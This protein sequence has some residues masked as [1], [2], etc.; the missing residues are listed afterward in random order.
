[1]ASGPSDT[2]PF[3]KTGL[4]D[5][6]VAAGSEPTIASSGSEPTIASSGSEPTIA[7][8]GSEPTIASSPGTTAA[9]LG[10]DDL[11][12]I[13]RAHYLVRHELARGGMGRILVA[14]DRRLGR[15]VALK[16]LVTR[17]ADRA[18]DRR[19]ARE[20]RVTARLQHPGI[21][22]VYEAGRWPDGEPF[23][24]MKLVTGSSLEKV[25]ED[26]PELA[27][28]LHLL[29]NLIQVT[30]AMAYAHRQG[31]IHRDLKPA[32]VLV[33]DFGETVV[34]DWGLAK[35][36][37]EA[38]NDLGELAE[39]ESPFRTLPTGDGLTM[40]GSVMGTPGYMAP[41]QARGETL[42]AR[43]DVYAL[44]AM[45]WHVL[46][47]RA[48]YRGHSVEDTLKL[49]K[50][51]APPPLVEA[52]AG[53]P[54]ELMTIVRRAMSRDP[55]DR[56]ADAG[57][58]A[59][60]LNRFQAGKLVASH[61]YTVWE[62]TR[63][64]LRRHRALVTSIAALL[65][66]G[67]VVGVLSVRQIV[68][69]RD[70]AH[71]ERD[72]AH[73]AALAALEE[74][75]RL[76]LLG[77]RPR[78][79]AVPLAEAYAEGR[80]GEPLRLLLGEAMRAVDAELGA[81]DVG[82]PVERVQFLPDGRRLLYAVERGGL[83]LYDLTTRSGM[84]LEA[85]AG[86]AHD[87]FV[88]SADGTRVVGWGKGGVRLWWLDSG[89]AV[90]LARR[91]RM[92]A[93][94]PSGR[95]ALGTRSGVNLYAAS[96]EKLV[97]IADVTNAAELTFRDEDHL[98]VSQGD[99]LTV[100]DLT[101]S[102]PAPTVVPLAAADDDKATVA[103]LRC[104]A[105]PLLVTPAAGLSRKGTVLLEETGATLLDCTDDGAFLAASPAPLR[106]TAVL[107]EDRLG[108]VV[109]GEDLGPP[110][111][112][113]GALGKDAAFAALGNGRG[114]LQLWDLARG[115]LVVELDAHDR[116]ITDVA[117]APDGRTLA[118]AGEDGF[119]RWW[120][121]A[122][123]VAAPPP[124]REGMVTALAH[125]ADD[126]IVAVARGHA[127]EIE[128]RGQR[129]PLAERHEEV[130]TW[131]GFSADGGVLASLSRDG[132]AVLG[133]WRGTA[134][135]TRHDFPLAGER[136]ALSSDGKTIAS[137]G[138]DGVVRLWPAGTEL[139]AHSTGVHAVAF[140]PGDD[141][142]LLSAGDTSAW[143][144]DLA[145]R[146]PLRKL[147]A[148]GPLLDAWWDRRGALVIGA[149][150][151]GV[152]VWDA[153]RGV[154]LLHLPIV[155][156]LRAT[157]LVVAPLDGSGSRLRWPTARG[158]SVRELARETRLAAELQA[159]VVAR[160]PWVVTNG[161][162]APR[163]RPVA[164]RTDEVAQ[165]ER[166]ETTFDFDD[167]L[168]AAPTRTSAGDGLTPQSALL[169]AR[170]HLALAADEAA[171]PIAAAR[172]L[173]A[174]ALLLPAGTPAPSSLT[175]DCRDV[176]G[177]VAPGEA[178]AVAAL[179]REL[180][181][182]DAFVL[183]RALD[184][185]YGLALRRLLPL[186][187]DRLGGDAAAV[188]ACSAHVERAIERTAAPAP[189]LVVQGGLD[190]KIIRR[191]V[192]SRATAI[193]RCYEQARTLD[194]ALEGKV[195]LTLLVSSVGRVEVASARPR[196]D[197]PA[198]RSLG[199]CVAAE[200]KTLAFPRLSRSPQLEVRYPLT[201]HP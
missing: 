45:M 38:E 51:G 96:G 89:K 166:I 56:H 170:L 107:A 74:L 62:L 5:P 117:F 168:A 82:R 8:S 95:I 157:P 1:M 124:R 177:P 185:R 7:S 191:A 20:V 129:L 35:D 106:V 67:I 123:E 179:V 72:R 135:P 66:G 167:Q 91:A 39:A 164:I 189:G 161:A 152:T 36:T 34:I 162:L 175:A 111:A 19:F 11:P 113:R 134:P 163:G 10:D 148:D 101:A 115:A 60:E 26:R 128:E 32:N 14:E 149:T 103:R 4:S 151:E 22:P 116:A 59:D 139:V 146:A 150:V 192:G 197:N 118:T 48:P 37:R 125:T 119:V 27:E 195:T 201:F 21:V 190:P 81:I 126:A 158:T 180:I 80:D 49:V 173:E 144:W 132:R 193:L 43:A 133:A 16:E 29:P 6:R 55:R 169:G 143:I 184:Y 3:G 88:V 159:L 40:V 41:E 171:E 160:V 155:E 79:A 33:G 153:G 131:L 23:Y 2:D 53:V 187:R 182:W 99:A 17:S 145:R 68:A 50:E 199:T 52:P 194:P 78:R 109:L 176:P 93:F 76:E 186:Y 13:A 98:E 47:G 57:A 77:G 24:A 105:E 122:E 9:G 104:G 71:A 156:Q 100:W 114:Q 65:V 63:R 130:V 18:L 15:P 174:A 75:G 61:Q 84:A 70:R 141:G 83:V 102:P 154:Q 86:W 46:V 200:T 181:A 183:G 54:P 69:A 30:E 97:E 85:P 140:R 142:T 138:V 42:D 73:A 178:D 12:R 137:G 127:I 25:V 108:L 94:S 120:R 188:T 92:A 90:E 136:A 121:V 87:G 147:D 31:V 172:H 112:V 198:M 64:W 110:A 196:P 28:R 165:T 44:G 58:L